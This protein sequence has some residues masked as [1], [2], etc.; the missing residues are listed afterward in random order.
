MSQIH[1]VRIEQKILETY[2]TLIDMKDY[3]KESEAKKAS[4]LRSRA[5]AACAIFAC[6]NASP[7]DCADSITDG[8]KDMGVDAIY[9]DND[10]KELYFV[11]S[12]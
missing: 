4:A 5:V 7:Q 6:T 1:V 10:A 12:K 2:G 8:Y 3:E 9:N 11:Q